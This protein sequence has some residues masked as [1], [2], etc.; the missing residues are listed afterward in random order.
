MNKPDLFDA[1][2]DLDALV[3]Y[4][5]ELEDRLRAESKSPVHLV[6]TQKVRRASIAVS[7]FLEAERRS[8]DGWRHSE[9][10]PT[11]V[12]FA[13]LVGRFLADTGMTSEE[14]AEQVNASPSWLDDLLLLCED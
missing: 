7:R 5:D 12:A 6:E 11:A 9:P 4:F 3:R 2:E 14:L 13:K 10:S 1:E 8:R